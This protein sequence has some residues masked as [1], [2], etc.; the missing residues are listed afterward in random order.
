MDQETIQRIAQ[1]ISE[2]VAG[3]SWR[4]L[5]IQALLTA[6]VFAAGVLFSEWL[7]KRRVNPS[8]EQPRQLQDDAPDKAIGDENWR[9]REWAN[10]RR[11][12]LEVLLAKMHDCEKFVDQ[13]ASHAE[14]VGER[15]SLSELNVITTLYFPELK[16]DVD[17]YLDQCSAR[18]TEGAPRIATAELKRTDFETTRDK[19]SSAA[20]TLTE[21]IMGVSDAQF[22]EIPSAP[23]ER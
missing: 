11:V 12:K 20:R 22:H 19:I 15:D 2:Q 7:R 21:K 4:L 8:V 16:A 10:L 17:H 18:K 1:E 14:R 13:G 6:L 9:E 3:H 23:R 5:S